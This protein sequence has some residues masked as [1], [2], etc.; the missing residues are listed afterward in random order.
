MIISLKTPCGGRGGGVPCSPIPREDLSLSPPHPSL[1]LFSFF[2]IISQCSKKVLRL[3]SRTTSLRRMCELRP[4]EESLDYMGSDRVHA[5]DMN[6]N[7]NMT[8]THV[9]V[10]VHA[11]AH[12]TLTN[13][14]A[15]TS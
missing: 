9:H 8:C 4:A 14:L 2:L 7:M 12:A 11:H 13:G 3:I 1:S 5:H 6:M 15:V 10:H